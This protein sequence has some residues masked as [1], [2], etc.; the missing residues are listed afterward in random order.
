MKVKKAVCGVLTSVGQSKCEPPVPCAFNSRRLLSLEAV[1]ARSNW[2][3][4][5]FS[6]IAL[7][8]SGDG[9]RALAHGQ[10]RNN[11]NIISFNSW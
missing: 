10:S 4:W 5:R 6:H 8:P 2:L 3:L 9:Y 11:N 7:P 1:I